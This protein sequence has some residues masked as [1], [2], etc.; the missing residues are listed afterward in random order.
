MFALVT[1]SSIALSLEIIQANFQAKYSQQIF[2][3][4]VY[5][6]YSKH[7]TQLKPSPI[8]IQNERVIRRAISQIIFQFISEAK[9]LTENNR[10]TTTPRNRS[11]LVHMETI[12]RK[13]I[14]QRARILVNTSGHGKPVDFSVEKIKSAV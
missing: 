3:V 14:Q 12:G 8:N 5:L 1:H 10:N 4:S 13:L 7:K 2:S 9:G 11:I 6:E